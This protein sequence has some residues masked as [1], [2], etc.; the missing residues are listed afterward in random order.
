MKAWAQRAVRL[1]VVLVTNISSKGRD[2]LY[3]LT[4]RSGYCV[5]MGLDAA[6]R[7]T[8]RLESGG[9]NATILA[10]GTLPA[11]LGVWHRLRLACQGTRI[12]DTRLQV[13]RRGRGV[14]M[15]LKC[16]V[17]EEFELSLPTLAESS[18][19]QVR[20]DDTDEVVS[21]DSDHTI[22]AAALLSGWHL[23]YFDNFALQEAQTLEPVYY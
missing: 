4:G 8:W 17:Q 3:G 12:R 22:G 7:G 18:A 19:Q 5:R 23:A 15:P 1:A 21:I 9:S 11:P 13:N 10:S 20:V 14:A 16:G 2:L 6:H